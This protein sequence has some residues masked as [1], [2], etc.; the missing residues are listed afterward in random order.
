MIAVEGWQACAG[1]AAGRL[2]NAGAYL[3]PYCTLGR[4]TAFGHFGYMRRI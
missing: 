2:C 4:L 3:A 1:A